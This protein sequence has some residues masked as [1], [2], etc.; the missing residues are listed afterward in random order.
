MDFALGNLSARAAF[1]CAW[2]ALSEWH[3]SMELL[4]DSSRE[5]RIPSVNPSFFLG[6]EF[7]RCDQAK[8]ERN[9][10]ASSRAGARARDV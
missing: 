8:G 4:R 1:V 6:L 3:F 2:S 10:T 5:L 7:L 9:G